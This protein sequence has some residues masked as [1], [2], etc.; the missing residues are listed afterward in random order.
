LR[1]TVIGEAGANSLGV[2]VVVH[3]CRGA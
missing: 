3:C 1:D 2:R